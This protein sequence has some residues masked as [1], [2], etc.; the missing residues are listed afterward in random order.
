MTEKRLEARAEWL[1]AV[2]WRESRQ[3]TEERTRGWELEAMA[4]ERLETWE[5]L[6][7]EYAAILASY[8]V[9]LTEGL[10]TNPQIR[11]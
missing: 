3:T 2:A 9:K 8:V 4:R 11:R 10:D 6:A 1:D 7:A 5:H